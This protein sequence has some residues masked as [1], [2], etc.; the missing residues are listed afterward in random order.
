MSDEKRSGG[1]GRGNAEGGDS[2]PTSSRAR[3]RTVMLTPEMTGHVRALLYNPGEEGSSEAEAD[4]SSPDSRPDALNDLLPASGGWSRPERSE[5]PPS[6]GFSGPMLQD[7]SVP[8]AADN[9]PGL[10]GGFSGGQPLNTGANRN[11]FG[12][13]NSQ[14]Q[15]F[16]NAPGSLNRGPFGTPISAGDIP[17]QSGLS[18][19]RAE[20][21]A[22]K[23]FNPDGTPMVME[24]PPPP[25]A[26]VQKTTPQR[27]VNGGKVI[28][29]LVSFDADENGECFDIRSGR[30]LITCRPTDQGDYILIDDPT[31]S[32]LHAIIRATKEGKVEVL[33]QLSEY[34]TGI[35]RS[36]QADEIEVAGSRM[37]IQHGDILRF[38]ERRFIVVLIPTIHV[39]AKS[40]VDAPRGEQ[41]E[42]MAD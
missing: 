7:F 29:F 28:G 22:T 17:P 34:G 1:P 19:R 16:P 2:K 27:R 32:P 39:G 33:D 3:N 41:K 6:Q 23:R 30:L 26:A 40:Q 9:G 10:G 18:G 14:G 42:S 25:P 4:S 5:P 11:A 37:V 12:T 8:H 20:G 36:G 24:P 31:V 38:G 15:A 35:T 21:S 13:P